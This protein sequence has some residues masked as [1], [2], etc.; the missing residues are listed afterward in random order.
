MIT[1]GITIVIPLFQ[2]DIYR[3]RNLRF[4]LESLVKTNYK[5]VVTE[6]AKTR[7]EA[8]NLKKFTGAIDHRITVTPGDK[9]KKSKLINNSC[10]YV[11]TSHIWVIDCDFY[12]DFAKVNIE[13]ILPYEFIQPYYYARDLSNYESWIFI[14]KP[15]LTGIKYY[16]GLEED[17][18]HVNIYGALSFIFNVQSFNKIGGMDERY[19]GWGHEDI[20]LF[21]KLH[22]PDR[23]KVIHILEQFKGIHLWHPDPPSKSSTSNKNLDIF[24]GKSYSNDLATELTLKY[25]YPAWGKR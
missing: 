3:V 4:I 16:K 25:H 13:D 18:R 20:D 23:G 9:I 8:T 19:E 1:P 24:T 11:K 21:L 12:M 15:D 7:S 6:Q 22:D 10:E 2:P 5:I 17:H 14:D